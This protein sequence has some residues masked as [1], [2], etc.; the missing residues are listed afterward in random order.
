MLRDMAAYRVVGVLRDMAVA[1]RD[2][3]WVLRDMAAYRVVGVL[4]ACCVTWLHIE[5]SVFSYG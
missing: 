5:L 1:L 2:D 3:S 4:L